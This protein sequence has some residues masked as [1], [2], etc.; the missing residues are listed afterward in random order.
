MWVWCVCVACGFIKSCQIIFAITAAGLQQTDS[1]DLRTSELR[2][3]LC[4]RRR[5][6]TFSGQPA[7]NPILKAAELLTMNEAGFAAELYMVER[8]FKFDAGRRS[9]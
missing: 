9:L 4:S 6:L 2:D 1:A 7:R 8:G 3:S 5:A